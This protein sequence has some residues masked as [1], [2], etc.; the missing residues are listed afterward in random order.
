M[1]KGLGVLPTPEKIDYLQLKQDLKKIGRNV[2]LQMY[3]LDQPTPFFFS[4][5]TSLLTT[6]KLNAIN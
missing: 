6:V 5:A 3:Y 4:G 2:K 1:S